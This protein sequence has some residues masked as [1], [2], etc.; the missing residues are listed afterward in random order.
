MVDVNKWRFWQLFDDAGELA[1]VAIS[2]PDAPRRLDRER[3]WTLLPKQQRLIANWFVAQ[4]QQLPE[5]ERRWV[6][7]S[8]DG[9]YFLEAAAAV[10]E[11]SPEDL[12]RIARPEAM[13]TLEQI[14][15]VPLAR[16]V[17][18]KELEQIVEARRGRF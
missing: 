6:H 5:N 7:D 18:K 1:W 13:L 2:R 12:A 3:V 10:P 17:S 15:D 8:I 14:T 4:D 11:P 16:V 9:W